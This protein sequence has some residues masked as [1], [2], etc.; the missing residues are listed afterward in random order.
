MK[1]IAHRGYSGKYPENTMLAFR[2]AVEAGCDGIELDVQTTK[3]GV[4]VVIHDERVDRTTDGT[5]FVKDYTFEELK[6][7][8]AAKLFPQVTEFE[9]VPSLEEYCSWMA[10]TD[11]FTNI[12]IKTGVYYYEDIEK[13]TVEMVQKYGLEDRILFSSFNPMSLAKAKK[14]APDIPCGVLMGGNGLGNAGYYCESCGYE[15]YH[16][17]YKTVSD[18]TVENCEAHGVRL[19]VWTVNDMAELEQLYEWGCYGVITNFPQVCKAYVEY[20]EKAK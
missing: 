17:G 2:K 15:Y 19:N 1:V 10:Q 20:K 12:E 18:Q 4:V 8:N 6:K 14:L 5:G 11:I 3:D 16:P 13:K 7:L 9:P